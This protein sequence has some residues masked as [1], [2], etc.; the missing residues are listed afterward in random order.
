[1][2]VR[3]SSRGRTR[4]RFDEELVLSTSRDEDVLALEE[5]LAK[6]AEISE[7][8]SRIVELRFYGGL[9]IDEIAEMLGIPRRTV[10]RRW[11]ATRLWLHRQLTEEPA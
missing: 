4:I 6:L 5:A 8:R 7:E 11:A 2:V 1:V 9:S 10:Q 3:T